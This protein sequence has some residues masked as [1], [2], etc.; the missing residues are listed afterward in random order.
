MDWRT[1]YHALGER[2]DLESVL[3]FG[4]GWGPRM[5]GVAEVEV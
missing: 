4:V 5:G 2:F 1:G 3:G